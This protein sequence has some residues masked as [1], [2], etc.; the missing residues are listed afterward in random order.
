VDRI[1]KRLGIKA[2]LDFGQLLLEL[3]LLLAREAVRIIQ[4]SATSRERR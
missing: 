1:A 3:N 4:S 2:P